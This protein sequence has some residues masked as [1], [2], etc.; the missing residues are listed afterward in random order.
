MIEII[1]K[2]LTTLKRTGIF[3]QCNFMGTTTD[4]EAIYPYGIYAKP[5]TGSMVILQSVLGDESNKVGTEYD[6]KKVQEIL[7]LLGDGDNAIYNPTSNSSVIFRAS[8][9][10]EIEARGSNNLKIKASV[11]HT[12]DMAI[13]GDVTITGDV[14]IEGTL[15]L[16]GDDINLH[17]H[18]PGTY[19][20][21]LSAPVTG[22]SGLI[23]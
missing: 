20:D 9:D 21:S 13:T 3:G 12:G 18:L 6:N 5:K 8:G 2:A 10:I 22:N 7:S 16:D 1:K 11:D 23:V 17:T 14:D 19:T 4:Y 15:T